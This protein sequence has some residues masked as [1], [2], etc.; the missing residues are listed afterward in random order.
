[1]VGGHTP[2]WDGHINWGEF[3]A[4]GAVRAGVEVFCFGAHGL[5]ARMAELSV[6]ATTAL[7]D[8]DGD[9]AYGQVWWVLPPDAPEEAMDPTEMLS[10]A[11]ERMRGTA[12]DEDER[13]VAARRVLAHRCASLALNDVLSILEGAPAGSLCIVPWAARYRAG[14]AMAGAAAAPHQQADLWVSHVC[15]LAEACEPI[16]QEEWTCIVLDTGEFLP[17]SGEDLNQLEALQCTLYGAPAPVTLQSIV[18]S[19]SAQWVDLIKRGL[20]ESAFVMIE[21]LPPV[22]DSDKEHLKIQAL[23]LA[24]EHEAA[25]LA[26]RAW[27]QTGVELP[28]AHRANLAKI[29]Q[30][31]GQG[32]LARRMLE[33]AAPGLRDPQMIERAMVL[34]RTLELEQVQEQLFQALLALDPNSGGVRDYRLRSLLDA[35]IDGREWLDPTPGQFDDALSQLSAYLNGA[36]IQAPSPNYQTVIEY[37]G[38]RW[39]AEFAAACLCVGADAE[40]RDLPKGV[41][42]VVHIGSTKL[43]FERY[44]AELLLWAL[45]REMVDFQDDEPSLELTCLAIDSM[46]RYLAR[47]PADSALRQ[48]LLE[49]LSVDVSGF[50]GRALL[51]TALLDLLEEPPE[52]SQQPQA[53][54]P[55]L[56]QQQAQDFLEPVFMWL[57]AAGPI[58]LHN[59]KLPEHLLTQ[60]ADAVMDML[61]NIVNTAP[62]DDQ[63]DGTTLSNFVCI[64]FA[65][66][67]YADTTGRDLEVLRLAVG[68]MAAGG[69]LQSARDFVEGGLLTTRSSPAR[70]RLAWLAFADAYQRAQNPLKSMLAICCAWTCQASSTPEQAY[71]TL[72]V[73]LR[74]LRDADL[75]DEARALIPT[76][77]QLLN[78]AGFEGQAQHRFETLR[79]GIEMKDVRGYEASRLGPLLQE[80]TAN[81]LEVQREDDEILPSALL[82]AQLIRHC[83][84]IGM[85]VPESARQALRA[86]TAQAGANA[87]NLLD[88]LGNTD[89]SAEGILQR[90]R[91]TQTARFSE[92]I[93]F[94]VHALVIGAR[95][96]LARA[97]ND[98]DLTTACFA[99]ELTT[100]HAVSMPQQ[101]GEPTPTWLPS[102]LATPSQ[103]LAQLSGGHYAVCL[104]ALAAIER[105][106][107]IDAVE[108]SL[109]PP[110]FGDEY[111]STAALRHWSAHFPAGYAAPDRDPNVFYTSLSRL[112]LRSTL[113]RPT[114]FVMDAELAYFPPQLL[115]AEG[116]MVG[117][118]TPTAVAPSLAWLSA[119][120]SSPRSYARPLG[121][122]IPASPTDLGTTLGNV[123][124]RLAPVLAD[125]GIPLNG[126]PEIPETLD[127]TELVIIAAH[128][129]LASDGRFFKVVSDEDALRLSGPTLS[130]A[131]RDAGVVVLFVCSGGRQDLH[132]GAQTST[133]LPKELLDRG[134]RAVIAS[135]WPL[136]AAVPAYWLPIFLEQWESGA[137]LMEATFAA[138]RAV[139]RD[140]TIDASA[141]LAM[142]LYGD[143][144]IT[145]QP[146]LPAHTAQPLG[147]PQ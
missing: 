147:N 121:A 33:Q 7:S 19:Q 76:A 20:R 136:D 135:P 80:A 82:L 107:L 123:A 28:P 77:R 85:E 22:Y 131:L 2:H 41:L 36:L 84:E 10:Q 106:V 15:E 64:A 141:C 109:S 32:D 17:D 83:D 65:V 112:G 1:M 142:T 8:A 115:M 14:T 117:S 42:S 127:H 3:F 111:F 75:A 6:V 62:I 37:C 89:T 39:H 26:L 86:A 125:F 44:A 91:A 130:R 40:R 57:F 95:R 116:E 139:A 120:R 69:Y 60:P 47:N 5:E 51:A 54:S 56:S 11:M 31:G 38:S 140:Y 49:I 98:S 124:A 21:A 126:M 23:H 129:N 61:V 78:Q 146:P 108:G 66:D 101:P 122:W 110:E 63:G 34:S 52:L 88:L 133:G 99:A 45:E 97:T 81:L 68:K 94:D 87:A 24:G 30:Q 102:D 118:S 53:T 128:G 48:R 90:L 43:E 55:R 59:L 71:Y 50:H 100:D 137:T 13:P 70:S 96:L 25:A 103:Q 72:L 132:P 18:Q 27:V 138:N 4:E 134:C 143:P 29:A 73:A 16:S 9:P 12:L 145:K 79:I 35:V 119:A 105:V 58:E 93:A 67:A 46:I 113:P 92:D 114:V 74:V 104:M 144:W